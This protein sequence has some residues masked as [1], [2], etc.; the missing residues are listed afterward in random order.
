MIKLLFSITV[1]LHKG[2]FNRGPLFFCIVMTHKTTLFFSFFIVMF[3][4]YSQ[5]IKLTYDLIVANKCIGKVVT[6]KTIKGNKAIYTSNTD[7]SVNILVANIDIK[8]RMEVVYENGI[9]QS[10]D[11]A[12][13]RNGKVKEYATIY[14][15]DG[16]YVLNHDG[17]KTTINKKILR[18]TI[19][20]PFEMPQDNNLYFEEVEGGFKIIKSVN[21][22][23]FNLINPDVKRMDGYVYKE[24]VM[25]KCIVRNPIVDFTMQLKE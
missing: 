23:F 4:A 6:T 2:L 8:T 9:L 12:F 24:G 10:S 15:I 14:L 25:Q 19:V 13:Y 18:S 11:Y 1:K 5:P 17:K 7:A 20:L 22:T 3:Y 16:N 21:T